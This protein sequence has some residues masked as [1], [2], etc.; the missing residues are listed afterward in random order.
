VEWKANFED[1]KEGEGDFKVAAWNSKPQ[2]FVQ[3][4]QSV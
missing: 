4:V 1:E 2:E 3:F